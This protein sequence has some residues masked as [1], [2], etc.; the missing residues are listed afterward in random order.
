VGSFASGLGWDSIGPANVFWLAALMA[1]L[2]L[3][4]ALVWIRPAREA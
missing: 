2:A 4:V 3:A 1:L